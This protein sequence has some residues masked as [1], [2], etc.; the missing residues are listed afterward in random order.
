MTKP[1][2]LFALLALPV[3]WALAHDAWVE[4]RNA[5]YAVVFGHDDEQIEFA[6]EK[7]R[8]IVALD[9]RGQPLN[10]ARGPAERAVQVSTAAAPAMW[11][12]HFDNGYWSK[13]PGNERAQNLPRNEVPGATTGTHAVKF[14]KTVVTWSEA[15]TRV[16]GQRLEIVP[17]A[18]AAPA[19]GQE[20]PVQVWWDGKPLAHAKLVHEGLPKGAPAIEADALGKARVAVVS[21][22]QKLTVAHRVVLRDDP[23]ADVY[24]AAANL[25]F[26]AR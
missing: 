6:A 1:F 25:V 22:R 15:V 11:V 17:L 2:L 14:G 8:S 19:A 23:R 9:A 12:L 21:G 7:V 26:T 10:V 20:L 5:G 18:G 16:Q 3:S 4:P 24:S 13:A